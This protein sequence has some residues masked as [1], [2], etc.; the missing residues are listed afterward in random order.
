M[1]EIFKIN[2]NMDSYFELLRSGL[3]SGNNVDWSN[4][5][6]FI[7]EIV[8][9][10]EGLVLDVGSNDGRFFRWYHDAGGTGRVIS[11]DI[12]DIISPSGPFVRSNATGLP[13]KDKSFDTVTSF[14]AIPEFCNRVKLPEGVAMQEILRV[15]KAALIWPA[16]FRWGGLKSYNGE[17]NEGTLNNLIKSDFRRRASGAY[18]L[19]VIN[20]PKL[21][22][23]SPIENRI[24]VVRT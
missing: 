22:M 9:L 12:R 6:P 17:Q 19:E 13:F 11:T 10:P 24:L 3:V 20:Q 23:I 18:D 4:K 8:P 2:E 5:Y 7:F 15:G 1:T 14:Y 16:P 21:E